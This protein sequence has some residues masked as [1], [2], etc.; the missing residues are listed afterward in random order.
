MTRR[1]VRL[2]AVAIVLLVVGAL[3]VPAVR[4]DEDDDDPTAGVREVVVKLDPASRATI[5][6]IN[7]T[8]GTRTVD[9]LLGSAGIV[10]L[11]IPE[12][13]DVSATAEAMSDDPRLLYAE[14]NF[15]GEVRGRPPRPAGGT[16]A[17]PRRWNRGRGARHRLSARP[18]NARAP[19]GRRL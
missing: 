15:V 6:D 17:Q 8:Y 12:A 9:V 4:A 3:I 16:H 1:I 14:P 13:A 18:S 19:A 7:A 10:L 2:F 11:E 5:E